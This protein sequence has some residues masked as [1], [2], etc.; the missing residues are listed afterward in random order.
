M[1]HARV[2]GT[3]NHGASMTRVERNAL[4]L[5]LLLLGAA[6][7]KDISTDPGPDSNFFSSGFNYSYIP[8]SRD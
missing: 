5:A 4:W 1:R 2:A 7:C 3:G 8:G 6:A